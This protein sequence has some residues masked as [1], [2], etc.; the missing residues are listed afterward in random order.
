MVDVLA[1]SVLSYL[2]LG[3]YKH[4]TGKMLGGHAIRILGWGVESGT[5]YWLETVVSSY[6][7]CLSVS[8]TEKNVQIV[9]NFEV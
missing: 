2:V 7:M 6:I 1:F 5:P 9:D 4:T 8:G 3:V